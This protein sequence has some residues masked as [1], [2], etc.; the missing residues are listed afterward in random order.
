MEQVVGGA[1]P[2]SKTC[3]NVLCFCIQNCGLAVVIVSLVLSVQ[4]KRLETP[5]TTHT[6]YFFMFSI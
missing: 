3:S 5:D 6:L 1:E 2:D 4:S